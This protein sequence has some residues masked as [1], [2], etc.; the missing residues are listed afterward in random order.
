MHSMADVKDNT[1]NLLE[2][3]ELF[4]GLTAAQFDS[5]ARRTHR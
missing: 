5:V 2:D 1:R 3:I 4:Q